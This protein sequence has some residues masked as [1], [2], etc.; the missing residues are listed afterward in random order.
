MQILDVCC[1]WPGSSHDA[2]IFSNSVLYDRIDR[3]DFGRECVILG[4]SA[5]GPEGFMCKPLR[6]AVSDSE[7]TYQHAQIKTRNV[8][9]RTF[10]V[11]KERFPCLSKGMSNRLTK[12]QDV[13]VA[14]CI[15]H[16]M[17]R[18]EN[19]LNPRQQIEQHEIDFQREIARQLATARQNR[20]RNDRMKISSFLIQNYF[21]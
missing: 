4:D 9:E 10:G 21:E 19:I 20:P 7:K 13:I 14:C 11:L 15:L 18:E 3:G 2:T 16:N 8:A 6:N 12:V 5:Y 1:R 17:I